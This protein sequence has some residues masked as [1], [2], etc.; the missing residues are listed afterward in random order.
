MRTARRRQN[1]TLRVV[2]HIV[3]SSGLPA[4]VYSE[5][6]P[7]RQVLDRIADKWTVL[8]VDALGDGSLRYSELQRRIQ[9]ISQKMLSKT[10]RALTADGFV[11]RSVEPTIPPK[12]DYSLTPLGESLR[13]PITE[14]RRWTEANINAIEL[15]RAQQTDDE[16]TADARRSLG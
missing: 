5:K 3:D 4:D 14:L 11:A 6:C 9:G 1:V 12:V 16:S 8:T 2:A 13:G 15:A 7:T 10:L